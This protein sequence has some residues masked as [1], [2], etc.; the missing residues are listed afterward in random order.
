MTKT[1]ILSWINVTPKP[2]V[3]DIMHNASIAYSDLPKEIQ[4]GGA[5]LVLLELEILLY[6]W[7]RRNGEMVPA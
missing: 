5:E 2:I 3:A 7:K 1:E 4:K 6:E